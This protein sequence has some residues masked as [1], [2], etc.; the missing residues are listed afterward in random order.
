MA[1]ACGRQST[2]IP[3][4]RAE[5]TQPVPPRHRPIL[6]A[7]KSSAG[8]VSLSKFARSVLGDGPAWLDGRASRS[9][10]WTSEGRRSTTHQTERLWCFLCAMAAADSGVPA[11]ACSPCFGEGRNCVAAATAKPSQCDKPRFSTRRKLR[12]DDDFEPMVWCTNCC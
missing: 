4:Q 8:V 3:W 1:P 11:A 10:T 2:Q 9:A 6:I 7:A 12:W 5:M